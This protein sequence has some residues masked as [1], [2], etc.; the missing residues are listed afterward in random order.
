[1]TS[2]WHGSH[3][4]PAGPG[5]VGRSLDR[6]RERLGDAL[7]RR[8]QDL[9]DT[10]LIAVQAAVAAGLAWLFTHDLM[11]NPVPV[12]APVTAI[13]TLAVSLNGRVRR[14]FE[15]LIGIAI[16][17]AVG[18]LLVQGIGVGSAQIALIVALAILFATLLG[19]GV[20]VLTQAASTAVLLV[21]F[22]PQM[23]DPVV[24]RFMEALIG[25]GTGLVVA[26]LLIPLN[27]MRAVDRAAKAVFEAVTG[28][29][30]ESA[31]AMAD[32]DPVRAGAALDR[33]SRV[34]GYLSDLE[35]AL[36]SGRE[37]VRFAPLRWRQRR[38]ILRYS[39]SLPYIDKTVHD[40]GTLVRRTVAAIEE[41]ERLPEGLAVAV[42]HLGDAAGLLREELREGLKPEGA[43]ELALL[44]VTAASEAYA[45][46]VGFSGSV[47]VAQV[48][49]A[50]TD[51]LLAAGTTPEDETKRLI[52]H[53]AARDQRPEQ[54]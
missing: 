31:A 52:R 10:S 37:T 8:V 41:G 43:R 32:R 7:R 1:M 22:Q 50:A 2:A 54:P 28:E 34:R 18:D 20:A 19:G 53:A 25:G 44:A 45:E 21:A 49:V 38:A 33:L 16:G 24:P 9:R 4:S 15:L 46:G 35:D 23:T 14:T 26:T 42:R 29:L 6:V 13:S 40:T 30:L 3:R 47:I 27:P 17:V 51:V 39:A 11:G 12:F 36:R 48:G 5:R